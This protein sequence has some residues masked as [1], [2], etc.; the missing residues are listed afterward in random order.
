MRARALWILL[1]AVTPLAMG[2]GCPP[3]N[4]NWQSPHEPVGHDLFASPQA[5]PIALSP[6][7]TRLYVANTTSHSVSMINTTNGVVIDKAIRVG[8]EPVGIAVRPDGN[9][10]WVANHVSDSV[11]VI[12][13]NPAS[14]N[15]RQVIRTIQDLVGG[16]TEFDEP[17]GIAFAEPPTN[18]AYVTL[19]SR[20]DV[21]VIDTTTYGIVKRLHITA[22]DPRALTVRGDFLYVAAF[23]ANNQTE[24]SV[25]PN[26]A[27]NP[28]QCTLDNDDI[29]EFVV[30]SPNIPGADTRIV[31]DPDVP[32]RDVFVYDVTNNECVVDVISGVGTLLYGVAAD[33]S[34]TL[35]VSQ[36]HARNEVNGDDGENLEFLDNRLFLNQIAE[37]DCS[38][39]SCGG[40]GCTLTAVHELEP[41]P[42]A[43][44]MSPPNDPAEGDQ[45]ATP[46]GIQVSGDDSTLVITAAGSS[47]IATIN[48]STGAVRGRLDVGAIPR[49]VALESDVA[50]AP[51]TAYVL[52]TLGNSV[53][54][55]DVSDPDNPALTN[56]IAVG[57]DPT[58]DDVRLGRIAFNDANASSTGTF[59]CASCHPD[60]HTDQLLWRIGGPCFF[61][62]C[63]GDDEIRSTMP[64]RGLK[65]TLPLHW[66]GTLGESTT[67]TDGS[68][69]GSGS[70]PADCTD[71]ASCLLHLVGESLSGVMCDQDGSCPTGG[72]KLT[73]TEQTNMATFLA[74]VAYPPA[75]ER[76]LTD[77]VST[78]AMDGFSDFF[79]DQPGPNLPLNLDDAGDLTGVTT[80][81]DMD[82]GCHALPLGVDTDSSTLAGFDVPTMRGMTDRFLQFSIG[83][84]NAE[85][86]LVEAN[87]GQCFTIMGFQLCAPPSPI[88]W[89][90]AEGFEEDVTFAA[91]FGIFDP[92]YAGEP[93]GMFQMFEEAST[94]TSGATG[95]QVTLNSAT[96]GGA[97]TLMLLS[98]LEDAAERGVIHLWGTGIYMGTEVTVSYLPGPQLYQ[99]GPDQIASGQL[100]L[101]AFFGDANVTLTGHLP[102]NWGKDTHPM[103][104]ISVNTTADGATGNP[105]LPVL[106][107]DNPMTLLG[108]DVRSDAGDGTDIGIF[109]DGEKVAGSV[110]CISGGSF[111]PFCS[112][113]T[114]QITLTSDPTPDGLHLLQ[115]QNEKGPMSPELPICVGAVSSCQ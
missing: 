109:V 8:M 26:A 34:D 53:S 110:T 32:D 99:V 64:V 55:V 21:A 76:S 78:T 100:A 1:V 114:V 29:V 37:I 44:H 3:G 10:V 49:G 41:L 108:I 18:R 68:L 79:V 73:M 30:E 70:N 4:S 58:P 39:A 36:V 88:P 104:L 111:S 89:D 24:L 71:D 50:G 19:S 69:G 22:Q 43:S 105:D 67:S 27:T 9:E 93:I 2:N 42:P 12:D 52:N 7:G 11:S 28:P 40:G 81:A 101:D 94:G 83:I 91:A 96:A 60:G 17:V 45:L 85:E 56:T 57:D 80:C 112:S 97:P 115:I 25:C 107:G 46:Y 51:E 61:G 113:N 98:D 62:A 59:S 75:R 20:N 6:D 74:S 14:A 16:V 35:F 54:F 15:Y 72:N 13:T 90:P 87:S 23:E 38:S 63:T 102:T 5:N 47:R 84:S 65:N 77:A 82:S 86:A 48:A 31:I 103:P 66:D 92:V 33:G 95:R 106:P